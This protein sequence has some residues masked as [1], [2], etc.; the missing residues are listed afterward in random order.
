MPLWW[1]NETVGGKIQ[2]N[3]APEEAEKRV[4]NSKGVI[5]KGSCHCKRVE[6]E[7]DG[8]ED[9]VVWDCNCSICRQKGNQHI[10][11]PKSN[12]RLLK[13]KQYI[14]TYTFNTHKAKHKFCQV[15]GIQSFYNPRSNPDG[16]MIFFLFFLG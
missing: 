7:F 1:V 11:I 9:I 16:V 5:H 8:K 14:T 10:I 2:Q 6:W 15:C 4:N 13:G 3:L 12:F